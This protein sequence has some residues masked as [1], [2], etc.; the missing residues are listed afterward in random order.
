MFVLI[1][2]FNAN[3]EGPGV[4]ILFRL[5]NRRPAARE[6]V[7]QAGAALVDDFN[8]VCDVFTKPPARPEAQ[9]KRV[10]VEPRRQDRIKRHRI[11]RA[12]R[13][14]RVRVEV[15][16]VPI[17]LHHAVKEEFMSINWPSANDATE[18]AA[19]RVVIERRTRA[20][21]VR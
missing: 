9:I 4:N 15:L 8:A 21:I 11:S 16:V 5:H 18:E 6:T 1:E 13:S 14:K 10:V 12:C 19:M 17:A 3:V 7:R 2:V 20:V